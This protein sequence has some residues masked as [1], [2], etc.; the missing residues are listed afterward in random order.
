MTRSE[1]LGS[2]ILIILLG[3]GLFAFLVL[4]RKGPS[5]PSLRGATYQI[6]TYVYALDATQAT[7]TYAAFPGTLH[8]I[9]VGTAVSSDVI[10]VYDS[11]TSTAPTTLMAKITTTSSTPQSLTFDASFTS[12]LTI[13]QSATSTLTA[14]YQQQ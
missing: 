2:A 3:V 11:N 5:S 7:T 9:V 10:S 4:V 1:K 8:T 12:G 6:S 13:Q 14:S